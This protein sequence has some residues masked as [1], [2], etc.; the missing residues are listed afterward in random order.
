[1]SRSQC[2]SEYKDRQIKLYRK[3]LHVKILF[4]KFF[5]F[6]SVSTSVI[7][8]HATCIQIYYIGYKYLMFCTFDLRLGIFRML[9]TIPYAEV[10]QT[11][12]ILSTMLTC[13][14]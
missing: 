8:Q 1:M 3:N 9:V 6:T 7:L 13:C 12:Q 5:H 14:L 11:E 10:S 2:Q 4:V